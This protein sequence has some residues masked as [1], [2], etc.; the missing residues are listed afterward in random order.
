MLEDARMAAEALGARADEPTA[1][2]LPI[3][4]GDG[5][6]SRNAGMKN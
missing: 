4:F 6:A 3:E 2:A 5:V 1:A